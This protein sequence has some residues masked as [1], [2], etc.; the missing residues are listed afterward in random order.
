MCQIYYSIIIDWKYPFFP[1]FTATKESCR[2]R[3]ISFTFRLKSIKSNP[4]TYFQYIIIQRGC[5]CKEHNTYCLFKDCRYSGYIFFVRHGKT[6]KFVSD[7]FHMSLFIKFNT[8][9]QWVYIKVKIGY[10]YFTD[11]FVL[12]HQLKNSY[13]IHEGDGVGD[14]DVFIIVFIVF[15]Y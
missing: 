12:K 2:K 3:I 13:H 10:T 8:F 9:L 11:I 15:I 4:D 7:F 6:L 14:C 5:T 1:Y